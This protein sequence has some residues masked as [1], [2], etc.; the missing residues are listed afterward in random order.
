MPRRR[1]LLA[2]PFLAC[3]AAQA[4]VLDR[5]A[6]LLVGFAPGGSA[7]VVGRLLAEQ[8]RDA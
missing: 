5:P 1:V 3:V 8:L 6:R 2:A 7:D 4:R